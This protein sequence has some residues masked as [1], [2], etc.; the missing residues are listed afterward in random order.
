MMKRTQTGQII[1]GRRQRILGT[2]V[3]AAL[4][5][6]ALASDAKAATFTYT[7]TSTTTDLWSAGTNWSAIPVGDPSTELTFVGLNTT[8]LTNFTNTNTDDVAGLFQLNI[9]DLQ[10]TGPAATGAA[11]ININSTSPATGLNLVSNGATS[12]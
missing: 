4:G 3:A 10:G 2:A 5:A 8:A 12:P 1:Q 11:T 9:L 7:P 6:V